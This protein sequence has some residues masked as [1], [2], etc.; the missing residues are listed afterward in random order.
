MSNTKAYFKTKVKAIENCHTGGRHSNSYTI[1]NSAVELKEAVAVVSVL[2]EFTKRNK[3]N[4]MTV[5]EVK[6]LR[7]KMDT[8]QD[9]VAPL[10]KRGSGGPRAQKKRSYQ[11]RHWHVGLRAG[12]KRSRQ[13][14]KQNSQ[15][16]QTTSLISMG[17]TGPG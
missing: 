12:R 14:L 3:E 6:R 15:R 2:K 9:T 10:E 8:L 17:H 13:K 1:K 5:N 16:R 7:K 11:N 4:T